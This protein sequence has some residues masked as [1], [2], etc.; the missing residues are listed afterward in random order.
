VALAN[1]VP[2]P[3]EDP[4]A[5]RRRPGYKEGED[6]L[7][8]FVGD[9][10]NDY[11]A[12]QTGLTEKFPGRV[13]AVSLTNLAASIAATDMTDGTLSAGL[14]RL[15]Y[16]FRITQAAS[17][18]SSLELTID[19]EDHTQAIS[20]TFPAETGN[21]VTSFQDGGFHLFWVD[22]QSP[23]RYATTYASSG[24]QGMIYQLY[25]VLTEVQA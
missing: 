5:Q 1:Q 3:T 11:F 7:E 15:D 16:Y 13:A 24:L 17:S 19:F 2:A 10:W 4:I 18:S 9:K 22:A 23:V 6:P 25:I 14:Y 20:H 12:H 8:G 21:L